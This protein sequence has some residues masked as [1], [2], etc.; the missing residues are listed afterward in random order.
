MNLT[1]ELRRRIGAIL[2][3]FGAACLLL[4]WVRA[5]QRASVYQRRALPAAQ[6]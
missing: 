1:P 2:I 5:D 3:F 4:A 6:R